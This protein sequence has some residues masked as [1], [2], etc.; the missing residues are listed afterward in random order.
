MVRPNQYFGPG[1][2]FLADLIYRDR[3]SECDT[4]LVHE[5]A[6][7]T[8]RLHN[9]SSGCVSGCPVSQEKCNP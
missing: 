9:Q 2:K 4:L 8:I 7:V 1:P 6:Q 5:H 3:I